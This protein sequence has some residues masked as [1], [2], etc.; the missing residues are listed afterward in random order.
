[1]MLLIKV[2][3]W[4]LL[5]AGLS[6]W[7]LTFGLIFSSIDES[8]RLTLGLVGALIGF[9]GFGIISQLEYMNKKVQ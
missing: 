9:T 6:L 4:F 8:L 5:I 1:M 7:L 3:G 2:L